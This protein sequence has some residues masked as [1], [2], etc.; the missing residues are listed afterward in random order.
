MCPT[1]KAGRVPDKHYL[2]IYYRVY[3]YDYLN[4]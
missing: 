3:E 4:V 1:R 2:M